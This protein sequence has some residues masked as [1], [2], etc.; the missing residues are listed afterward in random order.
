MPHSKAYTLKGRGFWKKCSHCDGK[1]DPKVTQG[2]NASSLI[3]KLH[4]R[5]KRTG[6]R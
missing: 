6:C 2:K 1:T 5:A 4:T 3:L